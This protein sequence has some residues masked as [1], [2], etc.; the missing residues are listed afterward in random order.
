MPWFFRRVTW[1]HPGLHDNGLLARE[2]TQGRDYF[3]DGPMYRMTATMRYSVTH[4]AKYAFFGFPLEIFR[5]LG[6]RFNIVPGE[7]NLICGSWERLGSRIHYLAGR[8]PPDC[9]DAPQGQPWG[10]RPPEPMT[11]WHPTRVKS[12]SGV[13]AWWAYHERVTL[14]HRGT[15]TASIEQTNCQNFLHIAFVNY[16]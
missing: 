10:R 15:L 1:I 7:P 12:W 14:F 2:I 9:H 11:T 4:E 13:F 16:T 8:L 5:G 6:R 3:L